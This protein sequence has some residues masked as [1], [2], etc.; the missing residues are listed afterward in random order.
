MLKVLRHKN[1]AKI[2]LWGILILILP[3]FV[4]W[5]TG[6][7]GHDKNKGPTFV[8]YINNKKIS[9]EQL[10]GSMAGVKTQILLNYFNQP[11]MMDGFLK[12]RSFLAKVAWDRLIMLKEVRAQGIKASDK[13]VIA[14]VQSHPLFAR[15]G[16]FDPRSYAHIL[17]YSFGMTPRNF[18]EIMRENIQIQKLSDKL[19]K[20]VTVSDDDVKAAY[21]D[22][23]SKFRISYILI[24][25]K[26]F[27]QAA[28][29]DDAAVQAYYEAHKKD[30]LLPASADE[31]DQPQIA[32][33]DEVKDAIRQTLAVIEARKLA[34][35]Q[36]DDISKKIADLTVEKETFESAANLL[37]LKILESPVFAKADYIEGIGE[38]EKLADA[39]S[40]LQTGQISS[41]VETRRGFLIFKV[42]EVQ[43]YS[44]ENFA[45]EKDEIAKTVLVRKKNKALEEWLRGLESQTRLNIN[46]TDF[47]K[48]SR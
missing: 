7:I 24:D 12:N 9:F 39:A 14:L 6:N 19:T 3:A 41:P 47:D 27:V 5:G 44:D 18:E 21:K 1:V 2:V 34:A 48:F 38:A 37:S 11:T 10:Y 31:G 20:D 42:A 36:A 33:L 4:I 23:G 29:V 15:D 35:A 40:K 8:G 30:F 13:E 43:A 26:D 46:F 25:P 17:Q 32:P 16:I 22:A 45:K 28:V